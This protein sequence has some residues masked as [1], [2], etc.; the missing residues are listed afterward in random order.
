MKDTPNRAIS[1]ELPGDVLETSTRVAEALGITRTEYI[2]YA[3]EEAN[4][5]ALARDRAG[6]MASASRRVRDEGMRVNAEFAAVERD[7]VA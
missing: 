1:L 5:Q 4:R 2:R 3:I 6:R 7:P